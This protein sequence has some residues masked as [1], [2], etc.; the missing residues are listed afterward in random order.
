LIA[1]QVLPQ[2]AT[3]RKNRLVLERRFIVGLRL[4]PRQKIAVNRRAVHAFYECGKAQLA[5][6]AMHLKVHRVA[7][8]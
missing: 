7:Q 6:I 8:G 1:Y 4:N 2:I 5:C 3:Q